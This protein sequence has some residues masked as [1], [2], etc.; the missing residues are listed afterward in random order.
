[1]RR[2]WWWS[3]PPREVEPHVPAAKVSIVISKQMIWMRTGD[4]IAKAVAH[5]AASIAAKK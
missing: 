5:P 4:S 3:S 2:R 1:M